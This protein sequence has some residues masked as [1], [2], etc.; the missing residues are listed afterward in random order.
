[1]I[2]IQK[3]SYRDSRVCA[4]YDEN[5]ATTKFASN[6]VSMLGVL[7]YKQSSAPLTFKPSAAY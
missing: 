7:Q 1:M 5:M 4:W 3:Y 2:A 6:G